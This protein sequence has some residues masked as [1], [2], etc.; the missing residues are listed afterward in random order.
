[1]EFGFVEVAEVFSREA[2]LLLFEDC[3]LSVFA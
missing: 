2:V 3:G 1:M